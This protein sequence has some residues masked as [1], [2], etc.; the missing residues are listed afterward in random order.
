MPLL[1][2]YAVDALNDAG[3]SELVLAPT[4]L[5]LAYGAARAGASLFNELRNAIFASVA[6]QGVRRL[7]S[8]VFE[9]LH[10]LDLTFHLSRQTGALTRALDRGGR[11]IT[12][13]L[14]AM[15]FNVAPLILEIG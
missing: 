11:G 12:F 13:V 15:V 14:N 10:R 7:S 6:Q 8:Q 5:L 9:H 2:K 4:G 1:F 3:A